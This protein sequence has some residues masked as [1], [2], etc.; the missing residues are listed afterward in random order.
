[1]LQNEDVMNTEYLFVNDDDPFDN[2]CCGLDSGERISKPRLGLVYQDY[3]RADPMN[4]NEFVFD[5]IF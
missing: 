1:M 2:Y 5:L 4:E 3:F